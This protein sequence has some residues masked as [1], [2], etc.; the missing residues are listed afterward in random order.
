[1]RNTVWYIEPGNVHACNMHNIIMHLTGIY[2]YTVWD[3]PAGLLVTTECHTLLKWNKN[4]RGYVKHTP[5]CLTLLKW[6]ENQRGY[7]NK[8]F[9]TSNFK[10]LMKDCQENSL[11]YRHQKQRY[12]TCLSQ[13]R[14]WNLVTHSHRFLFPSRKPWCK[15]KEFRS[16]QEEVVLNCTL[17]VIVNESPM[18]LCYFQTVKF[19]VC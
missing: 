7:V 5:E 13:C 17:Q 12:C 4:R 18:N 15:G 11:K 2:H 9:S 3:S 19:I 6:N 10:D 8:K 14:V 16:W 1:M